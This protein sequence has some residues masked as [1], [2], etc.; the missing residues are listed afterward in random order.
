M[1]IIE[2]IKE[3]KWKYLFSGTYCR[4]CK[5]GKLS[6]AENVAMRYS[7]IYVY[8]GS[9]LKISD[10]VLINH[11]TISVNHGLATIGSSSIIG[12]KHRNCLMIVENGE[13]NIGSRSFIKA[14]RIWIRFGG[15]C[16]IGNFCNINE[17]SEIRCDSSVTIGNYN[18][19]SYNVNIWDTNTHNIFKKEERRTI[20]E[21]HFPYFGFEKER[22][23]T[24]PVKIGDDCW[25]GQNV[26]ILK[27]SIIQ[28]EVIVGFGCFIAGQTIPTK[29][30]V[31]TD[32]QLKTWQRND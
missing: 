19:I 32:I 13:L 11:S 2:W 25:I 27:G 1:R 8:P 6:V 26:T 14:D 15:R 30:T 17:G 24:V 10:N 4:V 21:S 31:V 29:S 3:V 23:A 22:P 20:T 16:S 7:R 12:K 9:E 28:D 5:G 18:Q